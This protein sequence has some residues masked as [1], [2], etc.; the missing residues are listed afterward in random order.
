VRLAVA[1]TPQVAIPTLDFLLS[2]GHQL[3]KVF[4]TGDKQV[5]RGRTLTESEVAV[6]AAEHEIECIKVDRANDLLSNLDDVDCVITIA[7]GLLLPAQ[8]LA[9]PTHGFINLHFSLLPAWRGAAPVQRAIEEGD[10]Y[11]GITVFSLDEGM[12]TGPI[13]AQDSF[14]RDPD[15]RTKEA[16]D[17]LGVQGVSLI[18]KALDDISHG[19]A[20]VAQK[21]IG[22][23][24]ARKLSKEEATIDW[25]LPSQIIDCKIKAFYPNPIANTIFR[26]EVIKVT[27]S[28]V[29]DDFTLDLILNPG[30]WL[31]E[32]D[33][34]LIGTGSAPLEIVQLIP[35]GKSEMKAS[36]WARGARIS[37]GEHCG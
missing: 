7:F 23:S 17:F 5:G 16:L 6:W 24:L 20:P 29:C 9:I 36:D 2:N 33:R 14:L 35:Q 10:E 8:V 15:M 19:R 13:Y 25:S 12:D 4:T 26:N 28:K 18:V 30:Q 27:Q 32:K 3:V 37:E 1:A 21:N 11:L 31:V 34:V 22:V